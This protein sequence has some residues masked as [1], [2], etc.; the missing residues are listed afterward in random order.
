MAQAIEL[1]HDLAERIDR[2]REEGESR[3]EFVRELL[4]VYKTEGRFVREGYSE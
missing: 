3:E 1:A 4:D 2:H